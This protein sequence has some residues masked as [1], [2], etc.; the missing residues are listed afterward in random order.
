MAI[1]ME[2]VMNTGTNRKQ[3]DL[4]NSSAV[5]KLRLEEMLVKLI[6][7]SKTGTGKRL[8]RH[9]KKKALAEWG[10][11]VEI[12][13]HKIPEDLGITSDIFDGWTLSQEFL[14]LLDEAEIDTANAKQ[15]FD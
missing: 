7:H 2:N 6:M 3:K 13:F 4:G 12:A 5:T 1:F 9:V 14:D 11:D 15:L 8:K 10:N